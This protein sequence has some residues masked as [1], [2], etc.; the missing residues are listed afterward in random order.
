MINLIPPTAKKNIVA[1]YWV[2]VTSTWLYLWSFTLVCCA[3]IIFPAYI[4]ISS[5][6]AVYEDSAAQASA[7][8]A[9]YQLATRALVQSSQQASSIVN[10]SRVEVFST[11]LDLFENLQGSSITV[12]TVNIRRSPVGIEPVLISG[13]AADRQA[14]ASYRDRLLAQPVVSEVDLPISNLA[15][16]KDIRFSLTLVI[17][18]EKSL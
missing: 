4:L 15:Q 2:R 11:Y 7:K 12:S 3:A 10:E 9:D 14:L 13:V 16:D 1:E 6:V 5:Q 8:V 18:N 17:D